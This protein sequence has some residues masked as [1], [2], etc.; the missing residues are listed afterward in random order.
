VLKEG[1]SLL[2]EESMLCSKLMIQE[3][4]PLVRLAEFKRKSRRCRPSLEELEGGYR[5]LASHLFRADQMSCQM[6]PMRSLTLTL[7]SRPEGD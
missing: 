3:G 7:G 6:R 2:D 4:H 1:D 5:T